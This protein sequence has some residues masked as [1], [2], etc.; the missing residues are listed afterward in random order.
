MLRSIPSRA[1]FIDQ[2]QVLCLEAAEEITSAIK[3][4]NERLQSNPNCTQSL[5]CQ[6]KLPPS[7][8]HKFKSVNAVEHLYNFF[9]EPSRAKKDIDDCI[10]WF[11][12]FY[13][14][15]PPHP[16]INASVEDE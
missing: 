4:I 9:F 14:V 7:Y 10:N 15:S 16:S 11:E 5:K 6:K 1:E 3:F 8:F 13:Q 12:I 2:N